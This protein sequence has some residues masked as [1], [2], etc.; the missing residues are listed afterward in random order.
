RMMI[1]LYDISQIMHWQHTNSDIYEL[2]FAQVYHLSSLL[3]IRDGDLPYGGQSL[4]FLPEHHAT[5]KS[6]PRSHQ[7]YCNPAYYMD[8]MFSNVLLIIEWKTTAIVP[9][10]HNIIWNGVIWDRGS[11]YIDVI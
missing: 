2:I 9:N 8:L 10:L 7:G 5:T 1:I 3:S 4:K 6:L 11:T